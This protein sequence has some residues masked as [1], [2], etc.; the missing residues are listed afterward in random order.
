MPPA[1]M[2]LIILSAVALLIGGISKWSR[3]YPNRDEDRPE[4]VRM[5]KAV[6]VIGWLVLAVGA[7]MA[8]AAFAAEDAPLGERI[9]SVGMMLGGVAFLLMYRNFYITPYED[10]VVFRTVLGR[11]RVVAYRDIAEYRFS[12]NMGQQF[13]SIKSVDGVKLS[14]NISSFDVGPM[15]RAIDYHRVTGRWPEPGYSD[16]G[17]AGTGQRP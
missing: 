11:D 15:M 4:R 5:P 3:M 9:A 10:E 1:L 13:L 6:P 8:L 16:P 7:F 12:T 14:L 17:T 2:Y